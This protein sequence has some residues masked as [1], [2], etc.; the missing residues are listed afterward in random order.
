VAAPSGPIAVLEEVEDAL[1][2]GRPVEDILD[3]ADQAVERAS[4][5]GDVGSLER[6]AGLLEG[7]GASREEGRGLAVAALRARAA[8]A[9]LS[10]PAQAGTPSAADEPPAPTTAAPGVVHASL[11]IRALAHLVDWLA[12]LVVIGFVPVESGAAVLAVVFAVP[13][14]YFAGLHAFA[15]GRTIGKGLF[16][17]AV[18]RDDGGPVDFPNAL[19]RA[20]VQVLLVLTVI[21]VVVD[22]LAARGE[23]RLRTLHDR[24]AGTVVLRVR[25]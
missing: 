10:V 16:G 24:A 6:L 23:S 7:A 2:R 18:R 3:L 8:A 20:V 25:P 17:L 5:A 11:G 13:V 15:H 21:G 19:G 4:A 14:A 12:L 1:A 22:A 9:A